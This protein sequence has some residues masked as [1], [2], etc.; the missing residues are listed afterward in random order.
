M[1]QLAQQPAYLQIA[2][3]LDAIGQRYRVFR[4]VRGIILFLTT[5]AVSLVGGAML[6]DLAGEGL[7]PRVL[8]L[9]VVV[10]NLAAFVYWVAKPLL[11]RPKALE[12][13]RFVE[14]RVPGLNNA[15]TNGV[16]LVRADDLAANPWTRVVLDEIARD[17][18]D[19]PLKQAVRFA[20]LR[21]LLFKVS[22]IALAAIATVIFMPQ[23]LAHGL[24]QL[25]QPAGFVPAI[26][27]VNILEVKPGDATVIRGQSLEITAIAEGGNLP[28]GR[29]VFRTGMAPAA[30]SSSPTAD[31]KTY[32][33]YR[34]E[35]VDEPLEYRLEIGDSQT[36]WYHVQVVKQVQ[37]TS[38]RIV[39][40]PPLYTR[41]QPLTQTVK[42]EDVGKTPI[43]ALEGSKVEL[44]FELDVAVKGAML[45]AGDAAAVPAAPSADGQRF[46]ATITIADDTP[47]S[48]LL[49][50]GAGQI[51]ARLPQEPLTVH[52]TKDAAPTIEM[53]WPT[54]DTTIAPSQ[55]LRI[56]VLLK[57]DHGVCAA[58]VLLTH[59]SDQPM[60]VAAS[61]AFAQRPAGI[62]FSAVVK[63]K[64]EWARH[65]ESVWVQI[66]ATDN[67]DLS[68][69]RKDAGP[70]TTL[71][72]RYEIRFRDP[73]QIAKDEQ[74]KMDRLRQ[75]LTQMLKQQQALH[76]TTLAMKARAGLSA[77]K[78]GQSDLRT[79]MQTTAETFEFDNQTRIVQKTLQVMA[80][81]VAREAIEFAEAAT[82]EPVEKQQVKAASELQARQRRIIQTL[83][84][85]L[86]MLRVQPEPSTQQTSK[87]GGDLSTP[88]QAFKKLDE[89]LKEFIKEQQRILDQTTN[90]A[91]KPVDNFDDKDKKTLEELK[92]AQ[93]KLD[94]FMQQKVSD[95]SN[96]A[97]QDMAN[98]SLM[99]E[100]LEVYSEVTMAKNALKDK[101]VEMAISKEEMG[102][103]LAKEIS[104]NLEKWL[105]DK[106][107][108]QKWTQEDPTV[109]T[110]T[111]MAELPRELEDMVGELMEQ[112]EDLFDEMEDAN[113]NWHDSPDKGAG[114]DA[115]DGPIDS[116]AAKGVTGNQLPNNN[117]MGG[118]S[119]EGRSGK[120]Q[121]EM[122]E[123]TA[124]G[125]GGRN[126]PTRLDPTA[127]QQGQIKDESKDPTG[128]AT[129]GGKISGQGGAGLEGPVPA[130]IK[131]EMQRLAQ[132]QAELRNSAERLNLQYQ[133]GRYDNFKLL[134]SI[135]IMRRVESDLRSNRYQN[136]LRRRDVLLDAMDTSHSLVG[137]QISVQ[138]DTTP[139]GNHKLE[140]DIGDAMKGKLPAA[141]SEPLKE[142]YRKLGQE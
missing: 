64:P 86:A 120:S 93:E 55:D 54:Q 26:G 63:L 119:G 37:L 52:C 67:R 49:T 90:L 138:R 96:M 136:A 32:Y 87:Q 62:D 57:D 114:W 47:V 31:R 46:T 80:G 15:L 79:L 61:Q 50:D 21:A 73:G 74:Q 60:D 77:V 97:E 134:E 9:A 19:Q 140:Q 22:L 48:L 113:A 43:T 70:Q 24:A 59:S 131:Q 27:A 82:T 142:Y 75:R 99:K 25:R 141:W 8:A 91:K 66:E 36:P 16:L 111:P 42:A 129:G 100:L 89:A 127:F 117:E 102:L 4:L 122:V 71:S 94:A 28:P 6:A 14:T 109:K 18:A 44:A 58:R 112:Q 104:S 34:I 123:E 128:G 45:Q 5:A 7:W 124:T 116:M 115:A 137:G 103:E 76:E 53:K 105:M 12:I 39:A 69:L 92:M 2:D 125:K 88:P 11:L 68:Y 132:K 101:A 139:S 110:D 30:L 121:G 33:G 17:T 3:V 84:T 20:D 38:V 98:S 51:M 29:V 118:R 106:P 65:G 108:R 135:A 10:L 78:I 126:T 41:A 23:R 72:K 85:L 56:Q 133:V 13:A 83:E 35:H 81:G 95:F 130:K 107:D 1:T 40:T